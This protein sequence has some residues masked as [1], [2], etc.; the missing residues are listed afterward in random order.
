MKMKRVFL[1]VW[2][3]AGYYYN[4]AMGLKELGYQ[5][6]YLDLSDNSFKYLERE[7]FFAGT[8]KKI[9]LYYRSAHNLIGRLGWGALALLGRFFFLI[10]AVLQCDVFIFGFGRSFFRNYELPLLKFL[11]KKIICFVGHGAEA[12]PP[13]LD[14]ACLLPN[15]NHRTYDEYARLVTDMTNNLSR[16]EKYADC[17]IASPQADHFLH[18]RYIPMVILGIPYDRFREVIKTASSRDTVHVLHA[19]SNEIVKGSSRIRETIRRLI[20]RGY[21]IEYVEI[22][23]KPHSAV[24]E[25]LNKC[26]FVIDQLYSDTPLAG[27]ACEAAWFGKPAIVGGYLWN[28]L[29]KIIPP[30]LFP[31]SEICHPDELEHVTE[32]LILDRKHR[33]ELGQQA[34]HFVEKQWVRRIVSEKFSQLIQGDIPEEWWGSPFDHP[35]NVYGAGLPGTKAKQLIRIMLQGGGVSVLGLTDKPEVERQLVQFAHQE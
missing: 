9:H 26:D 33:E 29:E 4:L 6:T 21:R 28:I 27:F 14:G 20:S 5:V 31:V 8:L 35:V 7:E 19:P 10:W 3:I 17:I 34:R 2:E 30:E 25:E 32:R 24:M 1:G 12:R 15:G 18:R 13:Y 16:I 22:S 11:G 23:G